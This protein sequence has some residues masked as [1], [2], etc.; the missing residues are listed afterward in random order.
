MPSRLASRSVT[1][2]TI[3]FN[4]K[5][6]IP[7]DESCAA[8]SGAGSS[9]DSVNF[10]ELELELKEKKNQMRDLAERLALRL[11]H[12]FDAE[13]V[14]LPKVVKN[15]T[16]REFILQYGG[17]VDEAIQQQTKRSRIDDP[18]LQPPPGPSAAA[19]EPMEASSKKVARGGASSATAAMNSIPNPTKPTAGARGKRGAAAVGA[20]D[21]TAETPGAGKRSTRSRLAGGA[22]AAAATPAGAGA[23]GL[24]TP[25]VA[26][27]PRMGE[28]PRMVKGDDV[29]VSANGSPLVVPDTIKARGKRVRGGEG[30]S[31]A[32]TLADG[33]EMDL[34][35]KETLMKLEGD[36]DTKALMVQQLREIEAKVRSHLVALNAPHVPEM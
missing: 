33:K 32:L 5:E 28:K 3:S 1:Q 19:A 21:S 35:D 23:K 12:N 25:G 34:D 24:A 9:S 31:V 20:T 14:K 17:D 27:T 2:T 11:R 30:A 26:F 7:E 22:G 8:A 13:M 18:M 29:V 15:M 6:M 16:M 36:E 10:E 4:A